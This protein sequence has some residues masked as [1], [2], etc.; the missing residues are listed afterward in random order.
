MSIFSSQSPGTY[1][2]YSPLRRHPNGHPKKSK[3]RGHAAILSSSSCRAQTPGFLLLLNSALFSCAIVV[4]YPF[5]QREAGSCPLAAASFC[6]AR[7][8]HSHF[9]TSGFEEVRTK[10]ETKRNK[11]Q[12][13]NAT[14]PNNPRLLSVWLF[15]GVFW[16][17]VFFLLLF[18]HHHP[19]FSRF[20]AIITPTLLTYP[21]VHE[22]IYV[23]KEH[24]SHFLHLYMT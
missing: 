16:S 23:K 17:A 7:G 5:L 3:E 12:Q 24:F 18:R 6:I 8:A 10:K 22:I 13:D 19:P 21:S 2:L 4:C 11:T 1:Q 9:L 15:S 20:S 14:V